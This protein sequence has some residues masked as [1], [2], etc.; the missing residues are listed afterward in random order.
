MSVFDEPTLTNNELVRISTEEEE[1]ES[2]YEVEHTPPNLSYAGIKSFLIPIQTATE[3]H[4]FEIHN[5][6]HINP[7]LQH[8]SSN[9]QQ[10]HFITNFNEY[11]LTD[12]HHVENSFLTEGQ[13]SSSIYSLYFK[14]HSSSL[15]QTLNL[16]GRSTHFVRVSKRHIIVDQLLRRV[17]HKYSQ[18]NWNFSQRENALDLC[19]RLICRNILV[20]FEKLTL[21]NMNINDNEDNYVKNDQRFTPMGIWKR[22]RKDLP[23]GYSWLIFDTTPQ[24][25]C[26]DYTFTVTN[27]T[28]ERFM[29]NKFI[30]SRIV[31]VI[32]TNRCIPNQS[33]TFT[34]YLPTSFH[35]IPFNI[36][37]FVEEN[38][39][40]FHNRCKKMK[41]EEN[42]FNYGIHMMLTGLGMKVLTYAPH[43]IIKYL[44]KTPTY[45]HDTQPVLIILNIN[46]LKPVL[47]PEA[48]DD[49]ILKS[50][51][52]WY[53][54]NGIGT[55]DKNI[56]LSWFQ[57][58]IS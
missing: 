12:L 43:L 17:A 6:F 42:K 22:M 14:E 44:C 52:Y 39:E 31:Y 28:K 55:I 1:I 18:I 29:D 54:P 41:I 16:L 51:D 13:H 37:Y 2:T 58:L 3:G 30:N 33:V 57:Y 35:C 40:K 34:S 21:L 27:D 26:Y 50:I 24:E 5:P 45:I 11:S 38:D 7:Q 20:F 8:A 36:S 25:N 10:M 49:E 46:M 9:F 4:I 53:D 23:V 47:Y 15:T 19:I 32:K 56:L 48:E